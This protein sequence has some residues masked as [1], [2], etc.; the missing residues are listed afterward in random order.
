LCL[1]MKAILESVLKLVMVGVFVLITSQFILYA[2][3]PDSYDP[4]WLSNT[5]LACILVL[6]IVFRLVWRVATKR[7]PY[8]S[9][10]SD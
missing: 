5:I 7:S 10:V 4:H 2:V 1:L 9:T 6:I 8:R 3:F